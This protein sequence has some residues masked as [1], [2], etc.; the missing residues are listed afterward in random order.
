LSLIAAEL[1]KKIWHGVKG[2][3]KGG[4]YIRHRVET[5]EGCEGTEEKPCDKSLRETSLPPDGSIR[6][7]GVATP[8]EAEC[9]ERNPFI[10]SMGGNCFR[11]KRRSSR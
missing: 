3:V 8:Q 4:S 6:L 5:A 10:S 2:G 1:E 7:A 9:R 11:N